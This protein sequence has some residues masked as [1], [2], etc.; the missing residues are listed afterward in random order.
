MNTMHKSEKATIM[1]CEQLGVENFYSVCF[2]K[3]GVTL[4]GQY[5]PE[6]VQKL[7]GFEMSIDAN[8]FL[9]FHKAESGYMICVAFTN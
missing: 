2:T 6:V 7:Q 5:N 4:Q 9:N 3:S 8:G 1:I